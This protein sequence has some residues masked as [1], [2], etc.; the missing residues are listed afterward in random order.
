MAAALETRLTT[1][2]LARNIHCASCVTYIKDLFADFGPD[3][4]KVNISIL[5]QLVDVQHSSALKAQDLCL[6]LTQAAFD[7]SSASTDDEHGRM[8]DEVNWDSQNGWLEAALGRWCH[9]KDT[10]A[11]DCCL[12][13]P[14]DDR[15][16][17][18]LQNCTACREERN[19]ELIHAV[20]H[21][22]TGTM[23]R[24]STKTYPKP[25]DGGGSLREA[26]GNSDLSDTAR[27]YLVTLLIDGMTCASCVSAVT[28]AIQAL[29]HVSNVQVNLMTNSAKV[30]YTGLGEGASL[31]VEAV[32][33]AGFEASIEASKEVDPGTGKQASR[34]YSQET[35]TEGKPDRRSILLEVNGMFCNH[36]PSRVVDCLLSRFP[37]LIDIEQQPSLKTPVVKLTYLPAEASLT[38]RDIVATIN[39]VHE[40]ITCHVYHPPS[41]EDRSQLMQAQEQ[42]RILK[43]LSV[44]GLVVVP[45]LLIGVIW[46]S[47]VSSS[48]PI[49][50]YFET[51]VWA[52]TVTRA[53]WALLV[54]ATPV[55]FFAAN[56][57]HRRAL[58]EIW[59]LWRP[60][61]QV[62]IL[63]R[64]YRFG[65]MNLLISA[66]TSVAY[67][68]S[69]ALLA[70]GAT[71]SRDSPSH[72][73]TYFDSVV[74]LTFFILIGKYL[75]AYS[76]AKTGSAVAT[77]GNLRP[78]EAILVQPETKEGDDDISTTQMISV[79]LLEIG[80]MVAVPHGSSPPADG[81]VVTGSSKFNES[82]LTG[83]SRDVSKQEGDM[84]YAGTVNT[85]DPIH[86]EVTGLSGTSM[87]DQIIAVVREGQTK[88]APVERL[89]NTITGYFVPVITALAIITF[90]IWFA[91]GQSGRLSTKYLDNQ[92]GG[93]AFW[94]LEFAIALFVVACPCGIGLAAPTALFVGGGLAAK[95]GIL[96]QGG[97]EAFQEA[98]RVDAVVFDKTG[99]LTE[100][101][102]PTVTDHQVLLD[103]EESKIAWSMIVNL[104]E[105]SSHPLARALHQHA[106]AFPRIPITTDFM[107][108]ELGHGL[109]G[110]FT[111]PNTNK[112]YEAAIGSEAFIT[113]L[114]PSLLNYFTTSTLSTWKSQ[115]NSIAVLTLRELSSTTEETPPPWILAAMFAISDTIRPSA[116]PTITALQNR[117]IP[118]YMLTG[119]NPTTASAVASTL[120]IPADHVFAGM[121]P[122]QKAERIE[123]LKEHAPLRSSSPSRLSKLLFR[124]HSKELRKAIIAFVG[125]G[126]N[127]APALSAADVSIAVSSPNTANTS[128]DV[129]LHSASFILLSPSLTTVLTLL[130]LSAR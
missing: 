13:N 117:G 116:I 48:N 3:V 27:H 110:T 50:R 83:E 41:L 75:E 79:D 68:S 98:S 95:S 17:R 15:K 102:N 112:I 34:R 91:L 42:M 113:T 55:M 65:S 37:E 51:P 85:G 96:V 64:F 46:M 124:Q 111:I 118:V 16:I 106:S 87:L 125:D 30:E 114:Q 58:K 103:A 20:P 43:R 67:I 2:V 56:I 130:D 28:A 52:G 6:A 122:T 80:D 29:N 108:E 81:V 71:M 107:T 92:Q 76:K 7:V 82:S 129:A 22:K 115:S 31:I 59:A 89:V 72:S 40:L 99:T 69:V 36:C 57:F 120:S 88:R 44:C 62:P 4:R 90:L 14:E 126:I 19:T 39:G 101:V 109:R 74:F 61:S 121:L 94:S 26:T 5:Y 18:H 127:D 86:V 11:M 84:V 123:W 128:S 78:R 9:S 23:R 32:E 35:L 12:T 25:F 66:G 38:V 77:L 70:R 105:N 73:T 24:S 100:G 97:G 21:G 104:E 1:T 47:L 54:L 8:I 93:W 10:Q 63:R 49:R 33:D 60:K 45:T 119:D 53:Q